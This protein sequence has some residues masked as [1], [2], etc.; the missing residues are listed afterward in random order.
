M[1]VLLSKFEMK[2]DAI[3]PTADDS[4]NSYLILTRN[5]TALL[6]PVP[7]PSVS[8]HAFL[9]PTETKDNQGISYFFFFTSEI[10]HLLVIV[11]R[12]NLS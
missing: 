3:F 7:F 5:M 1:H 11:F 8:T 9:S 12:C 6:V 4:D 2:I 10:F